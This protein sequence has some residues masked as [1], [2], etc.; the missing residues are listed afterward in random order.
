LSPEISIHDLYFSYPPQSTNHESQST[1]H[2]SRVLR[3]IELEVERGEFVSIMGP[4]GVGKTTLCLALNGIVPQSTGGTIRGEV[5][6][7]GLNTRQHPVPELASLV[8]VVFQD[9]ESQFFNMTV[10]DEVAFGPESLGLDPR[11]IR[12]RVDWAL[13][14]VGMRPHRHR[15]PFQLSEGEKQRVAVASILAMSP[16]ILVL[17][18]PTSGL[19]PIGKAEVFRVIKELKQ[20]EQMTIIMVEQ[21]S[22]KIAEFSDRVVVLCDGKVALAD[23]PDRVFT[24]V[25]LMREIGLAVPQVSELAHLFN[26]RRNTSYAFISLEDAYQRLPKTG[27]NTGNSKPETRNSRPE[28]RNSNIV[29]QDLWYSYGGEIAALRGLD[30]EI[31]DGDYV[32]VIGQNGSGKTT[33]VK[34]FNGL[35]KPTR[36]RVLVRHTIH[37]MQHVA[38]KDTAGLTVGQLAQTVGYVFQNPDH[39]IFCATTSE[40]LA[41]GPRNLGLPEA[42]VKK[43]VEEALACF[44]LE[45]YADWP[46]AVLGY[47]LRRK[48]G[49]AAVY[50]MHPRIFILDE[51][52]IGLD[53]RST[54]ELMELIGEMHRNGHTIILVTHDMKLV[55]EFSQKSLVLRDGQVLVYDDT[56]TVFKNSEVLRDTQIEPPQITA[57]AKRMVPYG[58]PDDVL[59]VKEFYTAYCDIHLVG[60][61]C[62]LA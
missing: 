24:Q 62:C 28:T 55:A 42:E 34:H 53:W 46:P 2:E 39:Q 19:D 26:T 17:D 52:T 43:R 15:S 16:H 10:E 5:V 45:E 22:E 11:E 38:L 3:G 9:P 41:F 49:V 60:R 51:P 57:L 18:E 33:L 35:L 14:V 12:E 48:I 56:R 27:C 40:E 36:G 50:S 8:G 1:K 44:D 6:V 31:K 4:T 32:A 54:M 58:M 13:A 7:A 21:E 25:E 23:T 61:E 20:R 47:G 37:N 29:V 30:L 59:S